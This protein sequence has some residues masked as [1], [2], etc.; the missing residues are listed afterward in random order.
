MA[1]RVIATMT[2]AGIVAG[3]AITAGLVIADVPS[4]HEAGAL[5]VLPAGSLGGGSVASVEQT[6]SSESKIAA[7]SAS[8]DAAIAI[9]D[10][11][12]WVPP[13]INYHVDTD[14]SGLG[15]SATVWQFQT[16]VQ[17]DQARIRALADV[18]GLTGDI[19]AT[20]YGWDLIDG[21]RS[22]S[23]S[24]DAMGSWW[25]SAPSP[26]MW[27][28]AAVEPAVADPAAEAPADA[29]AVDPVMSECPEPEPPTGLPAADEAERRARELFDAAGFGDLATTVNA[30][31]WSVDVNGIPA[32]GNVPGDI[33]FYVG[34]GQDAMITYAG[35]YLNRP[36]EVGE[37]PLIDGEAAIAR[38]TDGAGLGPML[39]AKSEVAAG[40]VA[41]SS[42]LAVSSDIATMPAPDMPIQ[43]VTEPC[44]PAEPEVIDI[45]LT[46][47]TQVLM[48]W[49]S[50]DGT[51]WLIPAYRF[52]DADGGWYPVMAVTD[53]YLPAQPEPQPMPEP[54][55]EPVCGDPAV[56]CEP[57]VTIE[58]Q[59]LPAEQS[60]SVEGGEATVVA[61]EPPTTVAVAGG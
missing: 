54:M 48:Q 12:Y 33:G 15:G 51:V 26:T 22:L 46:G 57:E 23:V 10:G 29:P 37:Y 42:D 7:P 27:A 19:T 8:A 1:Q 25:Y 56:T 43:C 13:I 60:G 44:E 36:T 55:P 18:L 49:W 34:F 30:Y 31:E 28:C 53:E 14:I 17:P 39:Y 4:S 24:N 11:R 45:H 38:L 20:E 6:F 32:Y 3:A 58:P 16:G 41:V 9:A 50:T 52:T 40:D 21:D 35:G 47:V 59:P 2:A 61:T 5:P